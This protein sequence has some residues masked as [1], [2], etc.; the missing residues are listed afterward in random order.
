VFLRQDAGGQC[1]CGVTGQHRHHGLRQNSAMVQLRRHLVHRRARHLAPCV[2]GA[3]VGMHAGKRRQQRRVDIEQPAGIMLRKAGREDAHEAR[4]HHQLRRMQV[5]PRHQ[6]RVK[7]LA[8]RKV[9]VGQQVGR[10]VQAFGQRQALSVGA[11]ADHGGNPQAALF[12]PGFFVGGPGNGGHIGAATRNQDHDIFHCSKIIPMRT[13]TP[14]EARVLATLMEKARTVPD[15]YPLS[16]NAL[17]LGCNQKTSR[18]PMMDVTEPQAQAAID[19]LKALSL[20][21]QASS[22]RVP[23]FEHN[24]QRGF[25]VSEPQAVLLGLLML[26]GPQTPGELRTNS[27][28]WYKFSD[29]ASVED[30]LGELKARGEDSGVVTVMQLPRAAGM[31]EQRWVHLLCG[32]D[33]LPDFSSA[34]AGNPAFASDAEPVSLGQAERLQQRLETLETQV[35]QLQAQLAHLQKELGVSQA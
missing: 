34:K 27:E 4:Q 31:R 33:A 32:E 3:L 9:A 19:A 18:D 17:L 35:L 11:V 15:S 14:I 6:C 28:R 12:L 21:F 20:V 7:G 2:N 10:K 25:G 13:L 23:R 5:N 26:R 30:A 8:R 29:I 22:S 24:F 1:V 16:L